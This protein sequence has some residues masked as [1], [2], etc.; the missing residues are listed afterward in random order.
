MSVR[1]TKCPKCGN[2]DLK[3]IREHNP[4]TIDMNMDV[5]IECPKCKNMFEARVTSHYY[6]ELRK[7][8]EII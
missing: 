8:G 2:T 5:T 4:D 3:V 7:K 6:Q 1:L